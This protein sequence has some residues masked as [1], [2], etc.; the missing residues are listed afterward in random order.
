MF[1]QKE[2]SH[3]DRVHALF[4]QHS[5]RIRGYILSILPN[6]GRA[7][8]VLQ[9]TFLTASLKANDFVAGTNFVAWACTIARYKVLEECKRLKKSKTLLSP[10]AIEA[11]C[12]ADDPLLDEGDEAEMSALKKCLCEL[13]PHTRRA[14]DLRYKRAHSASEIA[15]IL[16]WSIDS[17]YVVLS[18]ARG[19]LQKCINAKLEING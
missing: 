1:S 13:S 2:P 12:A 3:Q 7:D 10:E 15:T 6:I 8:D 4:V 9:E 16:G 14:I 17:V 11:V 19:T 5:S 18:R